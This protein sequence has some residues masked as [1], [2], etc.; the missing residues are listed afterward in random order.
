MTRVLVIDDEAPIRLLCRVNLEAEGMEVLE[1]ADGP[2]GLEQ[3]REHTPDVVLLDVMMPGLDGWRV[4]EQLLEDERTSEI[5]IIF[6]TARAEF[7]DRAR[8]L[9]IGG[10]DYV[11]KPFNP[12]ELAPLVRDL[13]ERIERGERDELRGEKLSELRA[14]LD[15][16]TD[17]REERSASGESAARS[18]L[19]IRASRPP[20][21]LRGS[22]ALLSTG[23]V[24]GHDGGAAGAEEAAVRHADA[25]ARVAGAKEV[26][27]MLRAREPL[28]D[29]GRGR[30]EAAGAPREVLADDRAARLERKHAAEE[31]A[32]GEVVALEHVERVRS[33]RLDSGI[34]VSRARPCAARVWF[35]LASR[36]ASA[37]ES[38]DGDATA[39][40]A[41]RKEATGKTRKCAFPAARPPLLPRISQASV[42]F[43]GDARAFLRF[44]REG[45]PL[46]DDRGAGE[47]HGGEG[48]TQPG[49]GDDRRDHRLEHCRDP[50][51]RRAEVAE[52]ADDQRERD[53]RAEHD[54]P[55]HERP[56]RQVPGREAAL[57]R[58]GLADRARGKLHHGC[59]IVQKTVAKKKPQAITG[60][61][62]RRATSCSASSRCTQRRR[63]RI[64][65]YVT[66]SPSRRDLPQLDH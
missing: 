57:Q 2:T 10:V 46:Q 27:A 5:P 63:R 39:A 32:V 25:D 62:S 12:L 47:L 23:E 35:T 13:L 60:T 22:S 51:A 3:A 31:R 29:H 1:A 9:D 64:S 59:T 58:D 50:D 53:D 17:P 48:L 19:R 18:G 28:T 38:R 45:S 65:A 16:E 30:G 36:P 15:S 8:G 6:L 52:R 42:P 26:G 43:W 20:L 37:E 4:A 33:R 56:D 11:T 61:G 54:H 44:E 24:R 21:T 40:G 14:L 34:K 66:R 7:R 55:E 49:P 41:P